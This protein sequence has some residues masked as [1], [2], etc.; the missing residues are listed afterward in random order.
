[1]DISTFQANR[2]NF[3]VEDLRAHDGRWVA[4]SSDGTQILASAETL[5]DLERQLAADGINAEE[6][7]LERIDFDEASIIGGVH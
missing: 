6:V 7:G 2:A 5:D 4:F 1:M 3:P